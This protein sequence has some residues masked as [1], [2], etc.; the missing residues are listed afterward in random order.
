MLPEGTE[1]FFLAFRPPTD[2]PTCPASLVFIYV[3]PLV[4]SRPRG[5]CQPPG[6]PRYEKKT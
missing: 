5:T 3:R 2:S 1:R 4:A 6:R